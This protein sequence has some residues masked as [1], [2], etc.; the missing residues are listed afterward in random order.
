MDQ[1]QFTTIILFSFMAIFIFSDANAY[2]DP[3]TG[4]VIIQMIVA[5]I[6]GAFTFIAF[7][8]R[9]FI[10]FLKSFFKKIKK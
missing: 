9:K 4:S 8:Y 10:N 3:G 7:Y 6:A 1:R 2:I 5:G